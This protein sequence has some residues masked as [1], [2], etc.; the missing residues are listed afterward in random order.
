MVADRVDRKKTAVRIRHLV[1]MCMKQALGV[2]Q[3]PV[4]E[5]VYIG[6]SI[7]R[8]EVSMK[9]DPSGVINYSDY[10][11][12]WHLRLGSSNEVADD[13][14]DR[15]TDRQINL[16]EARIGH[17]YEQLEFLLDNKSEKMTV[18]HGLHWFGWEVEELDS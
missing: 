7:N 8:E 14:N 10:D 4:E 11:R 16:I 15:V 5:Y 12:G 17:V 13:P 18:H 6:L 3:L 2:N 9:R 1:E